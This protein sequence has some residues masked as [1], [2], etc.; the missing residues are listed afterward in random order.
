MLRLEIKKE[1]QVKM[2]SGRE[3]EI[4]ECFILLSPYGD[5]L[6]YVLRSGRDAQ[7]ADFLSSEWQLYCRALFSLIFQYFF[8]SLTPLELIASQGKMTGQLLRA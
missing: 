7:V 8:C 1:Q 3:R 6:N 2:W 4:K 5:I